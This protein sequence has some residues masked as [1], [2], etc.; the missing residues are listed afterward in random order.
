MQQLVSYTQNASMCWATAEADA[1]GFATN[2]ETLKKPACCSGFQFQQQT[3]IPGDKMDAWPKICAHLG[4]NSGFSALWR[5]N[6]SLF[7]VFCR[8][9]S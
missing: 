2:T 8:T 4:S 9:R 7:K 3:W 1:V 6:K 5:A